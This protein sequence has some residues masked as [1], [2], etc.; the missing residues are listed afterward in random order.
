MLANRTKT[1]WSVPQVA[2]WMRHRDLERVRDVAETEQAFE[3]ECRK[4]ILAS[5]RDAKLTAYARGEPIEGGFWSGAAFVDRGRRARTLYRGYEGIVLDAQ[6][7][8]SLWPSPAGLLNNEPMPLRALLASMGEDQRQDTVSPVA[9]WFLALPSIQVTGLNAS[10]ERIKVDGQALSDGIIG[11]HDDS[12]AGANRGLR[13]ESVTVRLRPK[14]AMSIG[15]VTN[16]RVQHAKPRRRGRKGDLRDRVACYL[17]KR[18][19][20]AVPDDLTMEALKAE[21]AEANIKVSVRTIDRARGR[22]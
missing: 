9:R 4:H 12:I 3:R 19:Q 5:L 14:L 1:W 18:Y 15:S 8:V 21:L 10:G 6:E 22:K 11:R 20:G 13:W 16:D 17:N 2:T 7:C